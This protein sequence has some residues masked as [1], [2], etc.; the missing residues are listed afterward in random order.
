MVKARIVIVHNDLL[1]DLDDVVVRSRE[2]LNL[3]AHNVESV[4]AAPPAASPS[5][6]R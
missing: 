6:D 2:C 5:R 1:L 3:H 4:S